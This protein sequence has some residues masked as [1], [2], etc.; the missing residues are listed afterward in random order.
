MKKFLYAVIFV[1]TLVLGLF[2]V[3]NY[4]MPHIIGEE[5]C[6]SIIAY[7]V[8]EESEEHE[9]SYPTFEDYVAYLYSNN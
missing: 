8:P 2:A 4:I 3:N 9:E 5:V 7:S 1:E 6:K